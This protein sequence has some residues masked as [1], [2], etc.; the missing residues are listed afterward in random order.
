MEAQLCRSDPVAVIGGGNSAGQ[1]SLFLAKHAV[2]VRLL[3]RHGDL[4]R[5]MSRYLG[6]QIERE[7]E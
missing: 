5:D 3:I 6:D 1:A 2:K 7:A 4:G